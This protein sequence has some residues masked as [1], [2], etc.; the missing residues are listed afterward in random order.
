MR[1]AFVSDNAYPWFNGGIEKRRYIIMRSLAKEGHEV[2]C[3]TMRHQH[4]PRDEFTHM[5]IRYHC[6]ARA[7]DWEGMYRGGSARRS[8]RMPLLFALS[9][10]P[11]MLPYRFDA[12]DA[13]SFPFLH[14][15]PVWL[16]TRLRGV[17]FAITWHEVWSMEF[18][19]HYLRG[20]GRLGFLAEWLSSRL[21]DVHIANASTTKELLGSV[22]GVDA[23]RVIT[24]PVAVDSD[25]VKRFTRG[26]FAKR[27][28]FV[29][30]A[31]LVSHKRVWL[32]IRA[33]A[34]TDAKLIVVGRGPDLGA[35]AK[36]ANEVAPGRVAFRQ[37]VSTAALY[38]TLMESRALLMTSAREGLSLAT[39][40][41][42]AAGVPVVIATT[43]VL[44]KEVRRMCVEASEEGLGRLL[45][46]MLAS[47]RYAERAM[48]MR[49]SVLSTFSGDS[50]GSVYRKVAGADW[51]C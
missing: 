15:F 12:V 5:G 32:A 46:E 8:I 41:A 10:L 21:A 3:F 28:Q 36:L 40:E 2:H 18:W 16:Y 37:A 24:F 1:F 51:L 49:K 35:L 33:V 48:R 27:R 14:L 38:R 47:D 22:L 26:R 42:L 9:I 25:E 29:S 4:M 50:S 20:L 11:A 44:P 19:S 7:M 45:N 30:I 34:K 31:R 43:S 13:D 6:V 23:G 39:I 17:R